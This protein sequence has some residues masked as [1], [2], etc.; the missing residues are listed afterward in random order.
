MNEGEP[1][2]ITIDNDDYKA[3]FVGRT[4]DN[5]Q[6][7]LTTPFTSVYSENGRH[8]FIAL[9]IFDPNGNLLEAR[10]DDLGP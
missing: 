6:F 3:E 2:L 4:K 10:I 5:K 9:Y 7:F 8:E 1:K